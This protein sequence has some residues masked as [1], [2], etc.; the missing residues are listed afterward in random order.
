MLR[1]KL[2]SLF[3]QLV[4]IERLAD[5]VCC[6]QFKQVHRAIYRAVAGD[7]DERRQ[8]TFSGNQLRKHVFAAHVRQIDVADYQV[9]ILAADRVQSVLAGVLPFDQESLQREA[10]A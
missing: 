9:V 7:E 10:V 4:E 6:S 5:V 2:G 1:A 3:D 8:R